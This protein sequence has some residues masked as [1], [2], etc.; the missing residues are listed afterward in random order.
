MTRRRIPGNVVPCRSCG[1]TILFAR[2][3]PGK[4][5]RGGK[6]IP[7]NPVEDPVGNV[8]VRNTGD[9]YRAALVA[10]VLADD[11]ALDTVTEYR[12]M[13]HAATCQP[14][15]PVDVDRNP[16]PNVL[17]FRRPRRPSPRG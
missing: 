14:R 9:Q 16:P 15:L 11:D 5:G 1:A 12:A 8:A 3:L 6:L 2:T 13:P 7:L 10:R 4:V 17:P